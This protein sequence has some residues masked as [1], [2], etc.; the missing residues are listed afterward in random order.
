M[1]DLAIGYISCLMVKTNLGPI[2]WLMAGRTYHLKMKLWAVRYMAIQA[3]G[4]F[5]TR[6][7]CIYVQPGSGRVTGRTLKVEM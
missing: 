1:A 5:Q 7:I 2:T 4:K 3:I 6:M